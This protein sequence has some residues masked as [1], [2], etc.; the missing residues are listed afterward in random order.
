MSLPLRGAI[1]TCACLLFPAILIVIFYWDKPDSR[2]RR[3]LDRSFDPD[4]D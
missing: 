2:V 1:L 3:Y 4:Q